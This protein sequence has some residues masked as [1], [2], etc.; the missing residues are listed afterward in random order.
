MATEVTTGL[1]AEKLT[2]RDTD[3]SGCAP[4]EPYPVNVPATLSPFLPLSSP[5]QKNSGFANY[6]TVRF[7][8]HRDSTFY[9][10]CYR[11]LPLN[12]LSLNLS[13]NFFDKAGA[14]A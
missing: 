2:H 9:G 10:P 8:S 12:L 11:S 14:L 13:L 6:K 1:G 5:P 4:A 3:R 7:C